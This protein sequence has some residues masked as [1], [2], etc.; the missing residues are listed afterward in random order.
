MGGIEFELR[1]PSCELLDEENVSQLN[2][3]QVSL[4]SRILVDP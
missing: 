2:K 3:I 1:V 4:R